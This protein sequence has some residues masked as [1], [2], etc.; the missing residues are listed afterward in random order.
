MD[1]IL[2]WSLTE[3]TN[4]ISDIFRY[5]SK[6]WYFLLFGCLAGVTIGYLL[7][8]DVKPIYTATISFVLSTE[9]KSA[10]SGLA[11]L[12]AQLGL[13]AG[14]GGSD[15]V[16][17]GDNII[18]LFKSRKMISLALLAEVDSVMHKSFLNYIA[19]SKY[20]GYNAYLPFPARREQF[21]PIQ[22][23]LFNKI[24]LSVAGTYTAFKKDKK[25]VFYYISANS[26][27]EKI[28]YYT[29]RSMLSQTSRFF[30][31]TKTSAATHGLKLLEKEADSISRVLGGTF[32]STASIADRTFNI[33]PSMLLQREGAQLNI[34]KATALGVAYTEVMRNIE[35]ARINLQKESPLFSIIDEPQLPLIAEPFGLLM[36]CV[37]LGLAGMF[38]A[39]TTL[40]GR[41]I[42][43]IIF[44]HC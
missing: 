40:S 9:S 22:K 33:N 6:R 25:L 24:I 37:I 12:S 2:E 15:N 38:L 4:V 27:N 8:K 17:S 28:A 34:A 32:H 19:A 39:A 3:W 7:K 43:L 11:G 14:T 10:N 16:F 42:Y 1:S 26:D 31:E 29:A 30:I 41:R 18:E 13:D 20:P 36:Y 35:V 5:L 44:K 23:Q 21:N